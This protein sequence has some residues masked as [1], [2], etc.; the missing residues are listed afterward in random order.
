MT[1]TTSQGRRLTRVAAACAMMLSVVACSGSTA[2]PSAPAASA[3][4]PASVAPSVAAAT[5][6]AS[7]SASAP[8]SLAPADLNV[9]L[10][11]GALSDNTVKSV[12]AGYTNGTLSA[13]VIGDNFKQKL[14]TAFT[15]NSGIPDITGIKGEDMPYFLQKPELFTDLNTLGV[16][17]I[18]SQFPDWKLKAATTPD[19]KLLGLPIDIGPTGL[20]YREDVLAKAGL[21][22]D[23]AAV[24]AATSTWADYF[25]FGEKLKAK[26]GAFLEVNIQD[27]FGMILAQNGT[28]FVDQ[29]GKF[30]GDS[31]A[32][33]KA[34]DTV[35]DA[36]KR[37]LTAGLQDGSP[38]WASAVSA[39]K[40]P[41]ILGAAWHAGDIKGS[42]ADTSGKWRVTQMPGGPAN[43]GGSFL[44]IPAAST[45]KEAAMALI[46]VLLNAQSEAQMFTDTG[47]FP[48]NSAAFDQPALKAP[49]AFFGG[50]DVVSQFATASKNMPTVYTSPLDG[51]VSAPFYTELNNV[52]SSSKDPEQAWKDAV[53]AAKAALAAG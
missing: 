28:G 5:S 6:A 18:L 33:R 1:P 9:W 7:A 53:D 19:G 4:A 25:T 11:P 48:A 51:V 43:V 35:I 29:N 34:W 44:T 52:E 2:S 15:A 41:T 40:L 22:T 23:P 46:R 39:G 13:S 50:Q 45:N 31:A 38:D 3:S 36:R 8:A 12:T 14:L 49:D 24:Q 37:G 30:I 47:N 27:L 20:F 21:P 32:V 16:S 17:D 26:T 10:W 42:V